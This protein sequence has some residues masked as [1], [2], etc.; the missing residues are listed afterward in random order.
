M[1]RFG[2]KITL[3]QQKNKQTIVILFT[4]N[5]QIHSILFTGDKQIQP[6]L[7]TGNKQTVKSEPGISS[8]EMPG[9]HVVCPHIRGGSF[10]T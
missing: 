8:M 7:F 5:K 1:V 4:A 10:V 9:L 3:P 2:A 6:F